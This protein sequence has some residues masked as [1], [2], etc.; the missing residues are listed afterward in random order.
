MLVL[1]LWPSD[2]AKASTTVAAWRNKS[3]T[4]FI[5]GAKPLPFE[6]LVPYLGWSPEK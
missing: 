3:G 4:E 5:D 2:V 6:T 1:Q